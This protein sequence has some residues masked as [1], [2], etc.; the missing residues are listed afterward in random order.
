MNSEDGLRNKVDQRP[1]WR[2]R[3]RLGL[4]LLVVFLP[5]A[6]LIGISQVENQ[7]DRR[8][9][10][11]DSFRTIGQTIAAVVDGFTRDLDGL[12]LATTLAMSDTN[13]QLDQ[14]T[15]GAYLTH[16]ADSYG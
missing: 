16:I 13:T 14:K 2:L 5:I 15:M 12:G 10:R 11:V 3:T 8:N 1:P 9:A 4:A 7:R 6:L